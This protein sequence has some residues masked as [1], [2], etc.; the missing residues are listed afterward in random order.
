M[1]QSKPGSG[2]K[3]PTRPTTPWRLVAAGD[4]L[5]GQ[6]FDIKPQ[7]VLGRD[8]GCD[9]TI[10][11]T[12]LSRRHAELNLR[13]NRLFVRDLGSANGTFL[14]GRQI[15]EAEVRSGDELRF[16]VL[17]F[18]VEGPVNPQGASANATIVRPA[19]KTVRQKATA[20]PLRKATDKPI[21]RAAVEPEPPAPEKTSGKGLWIGLIAIA[22]LA[23]IAALIYTL[24]L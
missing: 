8:G 10:A 16:D 19:L 5:A 1:V 22:V 9:I 3:P 7:T 6:S 24:P 21:P 23:G 20:K 4:W 17:P 13:G 12:H 18:R 2:A 11:G 14:N 15:T